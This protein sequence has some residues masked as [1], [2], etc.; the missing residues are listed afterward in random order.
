MKKTKTHWVE[1]SKGCCRCR[2][3]QALAI[4]T[5]TVICALSGISVISRCRNQHPTPTTLSMFTNN[6]E[7]ER[8]LRTMLRFWHLSFHFLFWMCALQEREERTEGEE[9]VMEKKVNVNLNS[10][11]MVSCSFDSLTLRHCLVLEYSNADNTYHHFCRP[12][13]R[14]RI[15]SS[16]ENVGKWTMRMLLFWWYY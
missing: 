3:L 15:C 5:R 1:Y 13:F 9:R 7:I 10:K 4:T 14:T 11:K 16:C 2:A 6:I 8:K 12:P